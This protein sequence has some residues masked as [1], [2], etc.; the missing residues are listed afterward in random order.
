MGYKRWMGKLDMARDA[1]RIRSVAAICRVHR[2]NALVLNC[3]EGEFFAI[4]NIELDLS[5]NPLRPYKIQV[6]NYIPVNMTQGVDFFVVMGTLF[7]NIQVIIRHICFSPL[8]SLQ[9]WI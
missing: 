5:P 1:T 2:S 7:S 4:V 8:K 3:N 6:V 9:P